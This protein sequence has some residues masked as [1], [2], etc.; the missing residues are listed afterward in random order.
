MVT[1]I[2]LAWGVLF[3]ILGLWH[4]IFSQNMMGLIVL[5]QGVYLLYLSRVSYRL[6]QQTRK[7]RY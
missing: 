3:S 6:D 4:T 1:L 7:N 2:T 5:L